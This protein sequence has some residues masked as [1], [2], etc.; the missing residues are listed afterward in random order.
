M[1]RT[2]MT[3][4]SGV[5]LEKKGFGAG[6]VGAEGCWGQVDDLGGDLREEKNEQ[7]REEAGV[8]V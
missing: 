1:L 2:Y 4:A 3:A 6:K 8:R 5:K 7:E